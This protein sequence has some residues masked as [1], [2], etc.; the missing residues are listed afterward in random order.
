M[1]KVKI[2]GRDLIDLLESQF[3]NVYQNI[4]EDD[5]ITDVRLDY[6]NDIEITIG[7]EEG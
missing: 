1:F 6:G 2:S 3:G 4:K 7:D 5:K